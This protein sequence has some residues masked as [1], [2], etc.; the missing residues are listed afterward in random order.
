MLLK[1]LS[2]EIKKRL[3]NAYPDNEINAFI[4]I[5]YKHVFQYSMHDIIM[6]ASESVEK[7]V[8]IKINNIVERLLRHEPIQ[9]I[10]GETEFFSLP[11]IVTPDILIPRNE[12]EE[13][14]QHIINENPSFNGYILDIGTGSGCIA[15]SLAMNMPLAHVSGF[16]ISPKAIETAKKNA[17]INDVDLSFFRHDILSCQS[18]NT[19]YNIIVSNPPYITWHEKDIMEANVLKYEPHTALFVPDSDPLLFYKAIAAF[20]INSL[21]YDG[22]L[23]L[24]IN[25]AFGS[26]TCQ[27]LSEQGFNAIVIKDIN[28]RDRFV[29]AN[30]KPA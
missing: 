26:E 25:E 12:T 1:D 29:R 6:H 27:M 22:V 19:Q 21:T 23:W 9:Y 16:D 2:G 7:N 4:S 13:L 18:S 5:I 10:L 15:I 3:S 24:E 20:A 14:V 28:E 30:K 17:K 11:F 8:Q